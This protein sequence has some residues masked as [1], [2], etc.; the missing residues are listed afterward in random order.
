MLNL[1]ALLMIPSFPLLC[2]CQRMA[3]LTL[4]DE[5]ELG[6]VGWR[7]LT[8]N[9]KDRR[10]VLLLLL[11]LV[12]WT[13]F[14]PVFYFLKEYGDKIGA[15]NPGWFF[16]LS[17]FTE[18]AVRLVAGRMFDRLDKSRS[19]A[20]SLAW[21]GLGYFILAH[22]SDATLFYGMGLFLG[23]GWGVAMPLLSGLMF[24]IS[25][26]QFRALNSNLA[27]EMFQAGFFVGPLAGGAILMHGGYPI[28]F[29]ACG[30]ILAGK[31]GGRD[32]VGNEARGTDV[33]RVG[34]KTYEFFEESPGRPNKKG[35][36]GPHPKNSYDLQP[37]PL[38]RQWLRL[39]FWQAGSFPFSCA[40]D[41]A[42]AESA[43]NNWRFLRQCNHF[44]NRREFR[45]GS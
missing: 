11:S 3:R 5:V 2:L 1:S 25:E 26:P 36:P 17:T 38:R 8:R 21:L 31:C 7:E 34:C 14:T 22:V 27:M 39:N 29:Y 10:V 16:T 6:R 13:S 19:L 28:L 35:L 20:Y 30:G 37:L 33:V 23:L 24:D 41:P 42:G 43:C 15:T 32:T 9:L 18:M 45:Q 44:Q 40:E 12:V 4:E